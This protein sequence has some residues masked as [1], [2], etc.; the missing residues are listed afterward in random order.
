MSQSSIALDTLQKQKKSH[1]HLQRQVSHDTHPLSGPLIMTIGNG[2]NDNHAKNE[3]V[4]YSGV[5]DADGIK[6]NMT[7]GRPSSASASHLNYVRNGGGSETVT[8]P[9]ATMLSMIPNNGS[10]GNL[11]QVR[12]H[13]SNASNDPL[14]QHMNLPSF[15]LPPNSKLRPTTIVTSSRPLNIPSLS[16][17]PQ[18]TQPLVIRLDT[19]NHA[20][21]TV[22]ITNSNVS[23]AHNNVNN[24]T[25]VWN[26]NNMDRIRFNE[27][28]KLIQSPPLPA[29][30]PAV[31][32]TPTLSTNAP[33]PSANDITNA[34]DQ[35]HHLNK[36]TCNESVGLRLVHS[37]KI[38]Q[39]LMQCKQWLEQL[40]KDQR[41]AFVRESSYFSD[42]T[43]KKI[44]EKLCKNEY[45]SVFAVFDDLQKLWSVVLARLKVIFIY[46]LNSFFFTFFCVYMF[47]Q[48]GSDAARLAHGEEQRL[49]QKQ[50][51]MLEDNLIFLFVLLLFQNLLTWAPER[52]K[53]WW[54]CNH[55]P[56]T[57]SERIIMTQ[58]NGE[59][60]VNIVNNHTQFEKIFPH[61]MH[62]YDELKKYKVYILT[63]LYLYL[64]KIKKIYL[65][66]KKI[67]SPSHFS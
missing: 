63:M 15:L 67:L 20:G 29:M 18:T 24:S 32:A 27:T 38:S 22:N 40:M 58:I 43:V 57:D 64:C 55:Y 50:E 4:N 44:Y 59:Q 13:M 56:E 35:M 14:V 26:K 7:N 11:S 8:T 41:L 16:A 51:E 10:A 60:L 25:H 66:F 30:E 34:I 28:T 65:F 42:N 1:S 3:T 9:T 23:C 53:E 48:K 5:I 17:A 31:L 37:L 12:T 36:S 2:A 62:I 61:S 54:D 49:H 39:E 21:T 46:F 19:S 45:K 47:T 52:V 33:S 6:L